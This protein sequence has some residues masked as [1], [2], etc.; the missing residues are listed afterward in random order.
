MTQFA[1]VIGAGEIGGAT[2]EAIASLDCVSEVR[3]IDDN[4]TAAAGKAL[5]A[6]QAGACQARSTRFV[7]TGDV[8]AAA[9][10]I[11]IVLADSFGPA[12]REFQGEQGLALVRRVWELAIQER[13]VIICAGT[14]HAQL[15]RTSV[16]ELHIDRKRIVGTAA[17]AFESAARAMVGIALDGNGTNVSLMVLGLP[18][19]AAVPCWSQAAVN[20]ASLTSRLSAAQLA[21]IDERLP[22]LWPPGPYALGSAAARAVR[23]CVQGT[24]APMTLFVSLDGELKMRNVVAALPVRLGPGGVLQVIEPDLSPHDRVRLMAVEG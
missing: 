21:A 9:G 18:P 1:A 12:S 15:I 19:A 24:R 10:A 13:S 17:A 6:M 5:D 14:T 8:R 23:A 4:S 7:G 16:G 2:I 20:G 22:A 11:A 3:L